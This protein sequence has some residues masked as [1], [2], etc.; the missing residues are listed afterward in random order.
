MDQE[1]K[2]KNQFNSEPVKAKK[3]L[4]MIMRTVLI[5]AVIGIFA[6]AIGALMSFNY[7][8]DYL[9][10]IVTPATTLPVSLTRTV[11]PGSIESAVELAGEKVVPAMVTFYE[12]KS[13]ADTGASI[14]FENDIL[15]YGLVF[16]SDGWLIGSGKSLAGYGAGDVVAGVG[17]RLYEAEKFMIDE[18]TGAQFVKISA[19]NLPVVQLAD[20][21][22]ISSGDRMVVIWGDENFE[23]SNLINKDYNT[24]SATNYLESSEIVGS[25]LFLTSGTKP[26]AAIINY[27]AEVVGMVWEEK[28]EG[29]IGLGLE[30]L[31]PLMMSLLKEGEFVRPY[32]GV[33]YIDLARV[34][35]VSAEKSQ[36]KFEGALLSSSADE[37]ILAVEEGSPAEEAGLVA[38][39]IILS[40]NGQ[41]LNGHGS[42]SRLLLNFNPG[43]RLSLEILRA[44]ETMSINLTLGALNDV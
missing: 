43:D 4:W 28:S 22:Y 15:G 19:E 35:G 33:R 21:D 9:T 24:L 41:S 14:Y 44:G 1:I 23:S 34:R 38:G 6:G 40:V 25:R 5:A 13:G 16:T 3:Q 29:T 27:N 20:D 42:L 30:L 10:S 2:Q 32:L 26:G 11:S 36:G 17:N 8:S 12:K 18:V 7:L 39:D 31:K 37:K